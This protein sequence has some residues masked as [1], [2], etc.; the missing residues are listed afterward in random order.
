[1]V[2]IE[3]VN[4]GQPQSPSRI[5]FARY[6]RFLT[7]FFQQIVS[8]TKVSAQSNH[9]PCDLVFDCVGRNNRKGLALG[10][11]F[12]NL[13]LHFSLFGRKFSLQIYEAD[14]LEQS[15]D[16]DK[17]CILLGLK[18]SSLDSTMHA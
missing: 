15:N 12:H 8:Q 14:K 5:P 4:G 7:V 13:W 10:K 2:E 3:G 1:M 11:N 6:Y 17:T 18:L 9:A 16:D